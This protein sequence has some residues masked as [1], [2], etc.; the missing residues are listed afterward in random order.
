MSEYSL[1]RNVLSSAASHLYELCVV[2]N[3]LFSAPPHV[4]ASPIPFS[5]NNGVNVDMQNFLGLLEH[6]ESDF[7]DQVKK[8]KAF[9]QKIIKDKEDLGVMVASHT[10][11]IKKL[12]LERMDYQKRIIEAE[13][14]KRH[15]DD[16][17]ENERQSTMA[18]LQ[19]LENQKQEYDKLHQESSQ[20]GQ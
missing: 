17:L 12:E 20:I 19:R 15:F 2:K 8:S 18:A 6:E 11:K 5:M 14:E 7:V 10:G 4:N 3:I 1:H 13:R 16:R 9:I